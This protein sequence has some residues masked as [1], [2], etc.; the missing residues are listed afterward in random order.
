MSLEHRRK[1]TGVTVM[2]KLNQHKTCLD[3]ELKKK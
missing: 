1:V 3:A 2:G